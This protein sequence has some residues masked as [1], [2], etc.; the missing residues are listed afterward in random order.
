MEKAKPEEVFCQ[1]ST[2]NEI[3][4]NFIEFK[5]KSDEIETLLC[6]DSGKGFISDVYNSF[7]FGQFKNIVCM[8]NRNQI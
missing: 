7:E 5:D 1:K 2:I 3:F 8:A 6:S 4:D